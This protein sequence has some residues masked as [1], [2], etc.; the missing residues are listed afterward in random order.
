MVVVYFVYA[1]RSHCLVASSLEGAISSLALKQLRARWF[2]LKIPEHAGQII[3]L[4]EYT[5]WLAEVHGKSH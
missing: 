3:I 2:S 4:K 1:S 5:Y